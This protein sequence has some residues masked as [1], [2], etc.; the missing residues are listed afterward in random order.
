MKNISSTKSLH[1][2]VH[3]LVI[4]AGD[5]QE[6]PHRVGELAVVDLLF[7]LLLKDPQ[8][9]G[10]LRIPNLRDTRKWCMPII[11]SYWSLF[12]GG[13]FSYLDFSIT[14]AGCEQMVV[15]GEGTAEHLL[16]VRLDLHQFLTCGAFKHLNTEQLHV[17]KYKKNRYYALTYINGLKGPADTFSVLQ[18]PLEAI[19]VPS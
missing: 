9:H 18:A 11:G 4:G 7:M 8:E 13:Q 5:Q 15:R 16:V 10:S 12:V 1:L 2:N 14:R 3:E 19:F 6:A 17:N